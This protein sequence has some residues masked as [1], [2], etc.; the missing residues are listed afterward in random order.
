MDYSKTLAVL[1]AIYVQ[2]AVPA[3]EPPMS[4]NMPRRKPEMNLDPVP[5]YRAGLK[6][7]HETGMDYNGRFLEDL[8]ISPPMLADVMDVSQATARRHLQYFHDQGLLEKHGDD[9]RRTY[10]EFN[11]E[12]TGT[13]EENLRSEATIID[14]AKEM[15]NM[16]VEE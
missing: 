2:Q 7:I 15:T 1:L 9:S 8:L 13:D 4:S 14:Y 16:A 6:Y 12:Y 5:G 11:S 10:Y 3:L